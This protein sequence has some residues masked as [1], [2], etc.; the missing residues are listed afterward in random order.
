MATSPASI[1]AAIERFIRVECQVS[2]RDPTFTRDAHLFD[3]GFIDSIGFVQL[4]SFVESTFDVAVDDEELMSDDFTTI[5]GI[6]KFV[7]SAMGR[8]HC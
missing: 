7:A 1:A 4:I 8:C 6:S 3:G 2:D 5:D